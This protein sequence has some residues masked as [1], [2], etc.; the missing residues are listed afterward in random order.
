MAVGKTAV[1]SLLKGTLLLDISTD[2]PE[3]D[4]AQQ[5]LASAT[6]SLA[7]LPASNK[8][9]EETFT[10]KK[11]PA[12]KKIKEKLRSRK[13]VRFSGDDMNQEEEEEEE[14]DEEEE[15]EEE[16]A[17]TRTA[18][19]GVVETGGSRISHNS[20]LFTLR[21][22]NAVYNSTL[23]QP[24]PSHPNRLSFENYP[25]SS[26]LLPTSPHALTC[27]ALSTLTKVLLLDSS[28]QYDPGMSEAPP[29]GSEG[30]PSDAPVFMIAPPKH[31]SASS[32]AL[33]SL[34]R[35]RLDLVLRPILASLKFPLAVSSV[36]TPLPSRLLLAD[37]VLAQG[38]DE[39]NGNYF[40]SLPLGNL[41]VPGG[42]GG[43][44]AFMEAYTLPAVRAAT[45]S[46][47]S[48]IPWKT[49][50]RSLLLCT[51]DARTRVKFAGVQAASALFLAGGDDA[52]LL[53]PEALPFL[54]ET[55]HDDDPRVEAATHK[56]ISHLQTSSGEDLAKYLS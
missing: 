41:G 24:A 16:D 7:S 52:L 15:E 40:P 4:D 17:A 8:G 30:T 53:L 28:Q 33:S 14:E 6:A 13:S 51:R 39:S 37:P 25:L 50:L 19:G 55:Q 45:R 43:F 18:G 32:A 46:A 20:L 23:Y 5:A 48:D 21:S 2:V 27:S 22:L 49:M 9:K 36:G 42:Q 35:E 56:L 11:R 10:S 54:S 3:M 29:G 44:E 1:L 47:R 26:T 12:V 34:S 31:W 38:V